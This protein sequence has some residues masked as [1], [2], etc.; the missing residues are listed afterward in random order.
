MVSKSEAE[1]LWRSAYGYPDALHTLVPVLV[2]SHRAVTFPT[3]GLGTKCR[4]ALGANLSED[5][6]TWS[7]LDISDRVRWQDGVTIVTG[8]RDRDPNVPASTASFTITNIDGEM[9]RQNVYSTLYGSL[10]KHNPIWI[11]TNVGNGEFDEFFGF[12]QDM[13]KRSDKSGTDGKINMVCKGPL[14][15]IFRSKEKESPLKTACLF[16]DA[17]FLWTLEEESTA[18]QAGS[19]L[20]G[21]SP[22]QQTGTIEW[23]SSTAVVGAK[24]LPN[25]RSGSGTL[26]GAL[27]QGIPG[28]APGYAFDHNYIV[29]IVTSPED[30]ASGSFTVFHINTENQNSIAAWDLNVTN[31]GT[32][33]LVSY[34]YLGATTVRS[35]SAVIPGIFTEPKLLTFTG[36][37]LDNTT[38]DARFRILVNNVEVT[39][40]TLVQYTGN[41]LFGTLTASSAS[42]AAP[43][44]FF[45]VHHLDYFS[46]D[47][48]RNVDSV[49]NGAE[50]VAALT[51]HAG[52]MVHERL[53]R[54][55]RQRGIPFYTSAGTSQRLGPQPIDTPIAVIRNA[56]LV[57]G[58]VYEKEFGLAY[59]STAEYYRQP[60]S[61]ALDMAQGHV[62]G[63]LTPADDT[64]KFYNQ[65]TI[66]R[67]GGSSS[68][69][70]KDG[71]ISENEEVFA[72]ESTR[73]VYEDTQTAW[74]ASYYAN[75]DS[76]EADR[77]PSV[78]F[79]LQKHPELILPYQ[80]MP[81]GARVTVDNMKTRWGV[82]AL[83]LTVEGKVVFFN[84]KQYEVTLNSS[85]A[86]IH[87]IGQLDGGQVLDSRSLF[88][89]APLEASPNLKD[90]FTRD[91]ASTW[92]D[93]DIGPSWSPSGTATGGIS[94]ADGV[95][96]HT[97]T[98]G[99]G[100]MI[101]MLAN[102]QLNSDLVID[103]RCTILPSANNVEGKVVLRFVDSSNF[104]DLRVFTRSSNDYTMAL[105]QMVAGVET[106]TAFPVIAGVTATDWLRIH[107]VANG[108]F[109][110]ARVWNRATSIAPESWNLKMVTTHLTAGSTQLSTL[111]GGGFVGPYP[112][113]TNWDNANEP[114]TME[115]ISTD[116]NDRITTDVADYPVDV[117]L[118]GERITATSISEICFDLM[119]RTAV[120][121]WDTSSSGHTV[122]SLGGAATDYDVNGGTGKHLMTSVNVMRHSVYAL[123]SGLPADAY[124]DM[125][126][127]ADAKI[128]VTPTG[129][130]IS[131]WVTTHFI[132][133]NNYYGAILLLQTDLTASLGIGV[134][135]GG[136][137]TLVTGI[138]GAGTLP[139]GVYTVGNFW[140][141]Q[142]RVVGD[143]I[144]AKAW[145]V[146]TQA[147]PSSYQVSGT[148]N[149]TTG[150]HPLGSDFAV[151]SRLE[152]GNTNV[153]PTVEWD[154]VHL[155][156][157]K[158]LVVTRSINGV[159]RAHPEGRSVRAADP[160]ILGL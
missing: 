127:Y 2:G 159:E 30:F 151:Q 152:P 54:V 27:D 145:Q 154:N 81:F 138:L 122:V 97:I 129:N 121:T 90:T 149:P 45:M 98:A 101:S 153:N 68:T 112:L 32:L 44:G 16:A 65:W 110:G 160:F 35:T 142:L 28:G 117:V 6:R 33:Q 64:T 133:V 40:T 37:L 7:W 39:T 1:E 94:V 86:S 43:L 18:T 26:V 150:V 34:D 109:F 80:G 106:V 67:S 60:V 124:N 119:D 157:P 15:H 108:S 72:N 9:S 73:N 144:S 25:M 58:V 63:E 62:V 29:S 13:P 128:S 93:P 36:E 107:V 41:L 31:T 21:G 143:S 69:Q 22:M 100:S 50:I 116:P 74:L 71:G 141:I 59:K 57:D 38:G 55:C 102:S 126:V 136:T 49:P 131:C 77:W 140:R 132:D 87:D 99:L 155:I 139:L 130:S 125:E 89:N 75:R 96:V 158:R 19:A 8:K 114:A 12:T 103:Y 47:Y 10:F 48:L 23:A 123:Q 104:I 5:W 66:T 135:A 11:T 113:I 118:L 105:R 17:T 111:V 82:L 137:L 120:D 14:D 53:A 134:R 85:D 52:D 83:N 156:N 24:S 46:G 4:I 76:S 3:T 84:S 42:E 78:K 91:A 88:L 95:G 20:V 56:E 115:V 51:G 148:A 147:E 79:L 61:I 92:D 70:Q 146:A